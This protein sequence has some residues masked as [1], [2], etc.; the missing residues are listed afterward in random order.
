MMLLK[1]D[2]LD[3]ILNL[4][5]THNSNHT[6]VSPMEYDLFELATALDVLTKAI[7]AYRQ[8]AKMEGIWYTGIG[9]E[10]AEAV[11]DAIKQVL[12]DEK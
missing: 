6:S 11:D 8:E 7:V 4:R 2:K 9:C 5:D 1:K 12:G 10:Y 3:F